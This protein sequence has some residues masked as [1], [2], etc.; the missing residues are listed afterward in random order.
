MERS[1]QTLVGVLNKAFCKSLDVVTPFERMARWVAV[2]LAT[3]N[4]QM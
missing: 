4:K 2:L 3:V 1:K